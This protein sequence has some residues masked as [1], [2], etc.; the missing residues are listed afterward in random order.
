MKVDIT[1]IEPIWDTPNFAYCFIR[2]KQ[3]NGCKIIRCKKPCVPIKIFKNYIQHSLIDSF[4]EID[5]IIYYIVDE[6]KNLIRLD[7][8]SK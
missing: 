2:I 7:S 6:N 4:E 3:L 8:Y 1:D 5:I